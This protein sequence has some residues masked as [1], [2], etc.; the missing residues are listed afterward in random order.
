MTLRVAVI[1]YHATPLAEPGA[2]DAG[3][4]TV[5]VRSIAE[6]LARLGVH[7]DIFTR[8]TGGAPRKAYLSRGVRV[9][10]IDAGPR[11]PVEKERQ[12]EFL[13]EF[14]TGVRAYATMQR[15]SYDIVHSHYWQSGVAATR[16]ARS[17]GTPMVH[18]HHT[19]GLVKNAHLAPGDSPE[20]RYRLDGEAEVIRS[21]DVLVASTEEEWQQLTCL[22]G[23]EHDRLKI[24]H[25]GVD[26]DRFSPGDRDSAR[27]A[28]GL[29]DEAVLLYAGRIQRLKGIDLVIEAVHQLAPALDRPVRLLVVGGPSG[30][31]GR[32]EL[33]RLR[34][35]ARERGVER[36]V[37]FLGP[38][39]H[40]RLPTYYRA[41]D[42]VAVPS[43]SESFGL[44]GLEAHACGVPIVA[45]PVGGLS[46]VVSD[47]ESG[48]LLADRDPAVFAG[49]LKQL[50]S[51][52]ALRARF[53]E[54]A[55][56]S[57][58]RFSWTRTAGAILELY[59]CL[60]REEF[61]E[62]CTC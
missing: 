6:E 25:P 3:G 28:L 50:L 12:H 49:H 30:S 52:D 39:P 41:S 17:W 55:L 35:L 27:S 36:A 59:D 44:V 20:P 48:Y 32:R 18:S 19:L 10:S 57:A 29:R 45:T 40:G 15:S 46:Y 34:A 8:A 33:M 47:G 9:V 16:L 60:I 62:A 23:A 51:D 4:M 56:R 7:T 61:P 11:A 53:S 22:Y 54:A 5:Y 14:V 1:A 42:V 26:H 24:L 21:A 2:G 31:D 43:H 37:S 38:Q 58:R 13:E